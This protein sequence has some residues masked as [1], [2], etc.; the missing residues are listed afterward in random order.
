MHQQQSLVYPHLDTGSHSI[1][2]SLWV[3]RQRCKQRSSRLQALCL[4]SFRLCCNLS[5]LL[6]FLLAYPLDS[7]LRS[8]H[9]YGRM[10]ERLRT[11][12]NQE[13]EQSR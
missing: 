10:R 12:D 9:L 3:L 6:S 1:L 13:V 2:Y 8:S 11:R 4:L 5:S 7:M